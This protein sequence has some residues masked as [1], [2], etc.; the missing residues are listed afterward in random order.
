MINSPCFKIKARN[1]KA[2]QNQCGGT[3]LEYHKLRTQLLREKGNQI[4]R[5]MENLSQ[6][7]WVLGAHQLQITTLKRGKFCHSSH[8]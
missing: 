1:I 2:T 6:V 3:K 5:E 7:V 4:H 8:N